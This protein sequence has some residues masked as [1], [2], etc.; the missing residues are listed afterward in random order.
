MKCESLFGQRQYATD[1][2]YFETL[3]ERKGVK[4]ERIL[5]RGHVTPEGEWYDQLQ[6]EWVMVVR[7]AAKLRLAGERELVNLQAGDY[8]L[9][10]AHCRHRVE[11]TSPD[12]ETVWLALHLDTESSEQ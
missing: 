5:S 3:L 4:L 7:G 9:L 11:W 12:E 10:P 2:E 1:E 8:I 6:D